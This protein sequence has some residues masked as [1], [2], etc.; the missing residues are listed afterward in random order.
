[1]ATSTLSRDISR[2][3]RSHDA[4]AVV[5]EPGASRAESAALANYTTDLYAH[6]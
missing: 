1:L 5:A 4:A 2:V 6:A 3:S